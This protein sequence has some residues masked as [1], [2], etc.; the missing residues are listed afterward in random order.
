[1]NP[2]YA[3]LFE[4]T[5]IKNM[6]LKNRFVM[7]PMTTFVWNQ[8]YTLSDAQLNYYE[9]R[10]RGGVGMIIL[11][12]QAVS[13][14]ID[15]HYAFA[16][17]AGTVEQKKGWGPFIDRVR[18]FGTRTCNQLVA[19][20]GRNGSPALGKIPSASAV[21]LFFDP[22][23]KSYEMTKEEIQ[24][25][26]KAFANAARMSKEI[27]FDCVEIHAHGGYL[28]DSFLMKSM[29]L[30]TDEYGGSWENMARFVVEIAQAIRDVTG[31]D[32]PILFRFAAQHHFPLGRTLEESAELLKILDKSEIDAFDV[33]SGSYE[34]WD[35]MFPP[36]YLGDAPSMGDAA[37]LK[38]YTDKPILITNNMTPD[39]AAEALEKGEA[40]YFMIGRGLIADPELPGKV[41][42]GQE[43]DIR[44]CIRC[45]EYCIMN[46]FSGIRPSCSINAQALQEKEFA[47]RKTE[48]PK[49][50]VIIG[51]GPGGLE[52]ARVA[53][54]KGHKVSL[55]EKSG[56]LGGQLAAAA[57]PSFKS[58]LHNYLCYLVRQVQQLGVIVHMNTE[59]TAGAAE[60]KDADEII[61]AVGG[62]AVIPPFRGIDGE[63]VIEVLDA[64]VKRRH[65]IG[66]RVVVAGGGLSGCDCALELAMEG[67]D[68]T[69]VE[70]LDDV[71][72]TA[73]IINRI[74]LMKK[75]DEF[76]V[77][78]VTNANVLEFQENGVLV[79]DK[80]GSRRLLEA[81]TMIVSFGIKPRAVL[82][83]S[84]CSRYPQAK[85]IGDCAAVG[86]VGEAVRAGFFAAWAID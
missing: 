11:E 58:Q 72:L 26:V 41:L 32:Y 63:N 73:A 48:Q 25:T 76:N 53:A 17:T 70:M 28:I 80:D 77:K 56:V 30:R 62:S 82:A 31:P 71:A 44:P 45:N 2:K 23:Q 20:A 6:A 33:D 16:K 10:A 35:W 15:P 29:N 60:L 65:E 12:G 21:P 4:R 79:G 46:A 24:F 7:C 78:R 34:T 8:D 54:L 75:L 69:I 43:K 49:N 47:I 27:G 40:D 3:K 52:A 67:K 66:S 5:T 74:A 36:S 1:M 59:I 83:D 50:I 38:K 68:V 86:Q 37:V 51:G 9:E 14:D 57:T 61:V 55:N 81:D 64:H 42:R 18:G 19:G 84:I 39:A 22:S 85:A 13:P